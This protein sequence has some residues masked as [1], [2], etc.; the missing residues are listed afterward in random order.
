MR[1]T[2]PYPREGGAVLTC[3]EAPAGA[4]FAQISSFVGSSKRIA[5]LQRASTGWPDFGPEATEACRPTSIPRAR[6]MLMPLRSFCL[7]ANSS[8]LPRVAPD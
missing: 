6:R 8:R 5:L 4:G 1:A 3:A 7:H 2:R